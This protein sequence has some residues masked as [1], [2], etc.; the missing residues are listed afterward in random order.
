[1]KDYFKVSNENLNIALYNLKGNAFKLW[2]YFADNANGHIIDLYPVDFCTKAGVSD[3]TYRRAFTELEEKGY[4][5]QSEKNE[6]LYLFSEYSNS[7]NIKAPDIVNS[8]D[9]DDFQE[10]KR[11]YFE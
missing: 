3:G 7:E 9:I 10:L 1:M 8:L 6:N 4:L 5:T 2:V 11:N